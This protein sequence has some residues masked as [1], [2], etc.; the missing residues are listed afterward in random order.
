MLAETIIN[1]SEE[2]NN[3][4]QCLINT[5]SGGFPEINEESN[6]ATVKTEGIHALHHIRV[7]VKS[8]FTVGGPEGCLKI[9]VAIIKHGFY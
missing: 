4:I 1:P 2:P 6:L 5:V 3:V 9:T 8:R 7:G